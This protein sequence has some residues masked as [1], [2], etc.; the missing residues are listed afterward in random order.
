MNQPK[1]KPRLD[2]EGK[3]RSQFEQAEPVREASF[4]RELW[5][6]VV[7]YKAWWLTPILITL[8]ALSAL[9]I[10]NGTGAAPF[11]YPFF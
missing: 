8:L 7:D 6:F 9:A 3:P 11:I 5:W 2:T 10:L 1:Q 4:L